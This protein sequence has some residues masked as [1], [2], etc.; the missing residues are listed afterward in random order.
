MEPIVVAQVDP[1]PDVILIENYSSEP[2]VLSKAVDV[3]QP[4]KSVE[5][6]HPKRVLKLRQ[7]K[8]LPSG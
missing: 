3:V 2:E 4:E 7:S 5:P 1:E 6:F 8:A